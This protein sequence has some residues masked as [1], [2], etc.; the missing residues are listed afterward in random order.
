MNNQ[1]Q[2]LVRAKR[3]VPF[4]RPAVLSD[5]RNLYQEDPELLY[6]LC[7]I[8]VPEDAPSSAIGIQSIARSLAI[9]ARD[10][11]EV[12]SRAGQHIAEGTR[13]GYVVLEDFTAD[14]EFLERVYAGGHQNKSLQGVEVSRDR[15][16]FYLGKFDMH[17]SIRRTHLLRIAPQDA[18]AVV[19]GAPRHQFHELLDCAREVVRAPTKVWTGLREPEQRLWGRAYCGQPSRRWLNSGK[20]AAPAD[21]FVY[22]VY[23]DSDGM[24]FDWDWVKADPADPQLPDS[25]A[26]RFGSCVE[27]PDPAELLVG[28]IKGQAPAAFKAGQSSYSVTGDCLFCYFEDRESYASRVDDY[29]TAFLPLDMQKHPSVGFKLKHVSRLLE[30]V[31]KW[32]KAKEEGILVSFDPDTISVKVFFLMQAWLAQ[33]LPLTEELNPA[34]ELMQLMQRV[35]QAGNPE[36]NVPRS[37]LQEA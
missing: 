29:L 15:L 28:N 34:M 7:T 20:S 37:V 19:G 18:S 14:K 16:D 33:N 21:G 35:Q 9:L 3:F 26:K 25:H 4:D 27:T 24:V 31:S 30:T 23:A 1:Q 36:V 8:G 10:G 17:D 5:I 2:V 13:G 22:L 6:Q 12:I 11:F 32:A